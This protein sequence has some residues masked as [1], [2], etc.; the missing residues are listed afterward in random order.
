MR[1]AQ[2]RNEKRT[3][4]CC[5]QCP[6][7]FEDHHRHIQLFFSTKHRSSNW[8][9]KVNTVTK[10]DDF[11]LPCME[12][13]IDQ[14]GQAKYTT[15]FN[16]PVSGLMSLSVLWWLNLTYMRLLTRIDP[17]FGQSQKVQHLSFHAALWNVEDQIKSRRGIKLSRTN[18]LKLQENKTSKP[19]E[20]QIP[21]G[22][23]R[24]WHRREGEHTLYCRWRD[25][26]TQV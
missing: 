9:P 22:V 15:K 16:L 7:F 1:G 12:D 5:L 17:Q 14:V 6:L 10:P 25:S 21:T 11:R 19:G 18:S 13:C 3:R 4:D 2:D 26:E 8:F 23:K 20:I 24:V